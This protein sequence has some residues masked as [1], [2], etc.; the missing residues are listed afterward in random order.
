MKIEDLYFPPPDSPVDEKNFDLEKWRR[1][2]PMDYFKAVYVLQQG[3]GILQ[4]EIF[5]SIYRVVRLYLPDTLY[6]YY[7]LTD[8][9]ELNAKKL[10]TLMSK[11]IFLSD[12][13]DFNDP[14]DSKAFYYDPECLKISPELNR[15]D[16]KLIDD[17]TTYIK[18][19]SLTANDVQSMPMWAH[20]AGNHTGFCVS[21]DMKSNLKLSSC[22]FPV[23][24]SEERLDITGFMK[25]YT[26]MLL[27]EISKQRSLGNK[28]IVVG[29][30]SI[31]YVTLLLSNI[32]HTSWSYEKEYRCTIASNAPE[33]PYVD[34]IPKEIFVGLKCS[35][36]N[37]IKLQE[38]G[39]K[40][41]VPVR[42]MEFDEISPF[43]KLSVIQKEDAGTK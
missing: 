7:S 43:Y 4:D 12:I 11:K 5:K 33:S 37:A 20:Y 10:E 28:Q 21:Y 13:K 36:K 14:F 30:S 3:K 42:R 32:K 15:C 6:K 17:F 8:D 23:Q 39:D 22:T 26:E 19:T 41:G 27:E 16:G 34:A 35:E 2:C 25:K 18:S 1:E 24:Y 29:D 31:I 40:L 38:I 9:Q